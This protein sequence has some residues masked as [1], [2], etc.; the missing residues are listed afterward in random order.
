VIGG[1]SRREIFTGVFPR[2]FNRCAGKV[3]AVFGLSA[4]NESGWEG[5]WSS[6][7]TRLRWRSQGRIKLARRLEEV[8]RQ[9]RIGS[10]SR[11]RVFGWEGEEEG[12]RDSF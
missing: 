10:G 4:V 6:W 5:R 2:K 3:R 7:E 8:V 9:R 12:R 1:R 11:N